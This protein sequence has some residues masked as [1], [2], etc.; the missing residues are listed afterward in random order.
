MEIK[1]LKILIDVDIIFVN[2]VFH[3]CHYIYAKLVDLTL[4]LIIVYIRRNI[5]FI[6]SEFYFY[7]S[8]FYY[9]FTLCLLCYNSYLV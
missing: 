5:F 2:K 3:D 4:K 1:E 6:Y 7:F 9:S 8:L